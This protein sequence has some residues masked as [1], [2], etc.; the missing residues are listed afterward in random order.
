MSTHPTTITG[1]ATGTRPEFAR[2][3]AALAAAGIEFTVVEESDG[4]DV[5]A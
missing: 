1:A 4:W 3:M 2:A 5:A